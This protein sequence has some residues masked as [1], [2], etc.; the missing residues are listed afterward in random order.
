MTASH[1]ASRPATEPIAII[2]MAC[3]YPQAPDLARFWHNIIQGV[4]AVGEPVA[5][6]DA[7]RYLDSGRIKTA[8]GGYLKDLYRFDPREFGIMPNSLDGGE[9]DQFLALKVAAEALKD[10]GYLDLSHDHRD[11]GIVLGHSTYLHRGQGT[12]IQNHIVID[13][14]LDVLRSTCPHLEPEALEEV[15][16]LLAAKLPAA[17]PDIAPGLVPNV[18]TG[19]IANRLNL[20]GPN[21]LVDAACSSSLLAVNAAIDELRLGR[22]RLMIA[23]GVNASLPAEVSVIFTQLGALSGRGRVRPFETGSDGTLLGEGLGMV[24]LKRLGDALQDGDRI[25]AVLRGVGQASDGRGTGL[26][27]PSV[28]GESLAIRRAYADSGVEPASVSLIEA[29]GTGIPLGDKTEIAALKSVFGERRAGQGSM[30]LGSVKSMISHTIPAAGMAGLI[31][32]ALA[33][34]HKVLPPM[35][36]AEVNPDLGID[37]TPLYV[38]NRPAP[39]VAPQGRPR[40]AGVNSFGFGGINT[41]AILEEAP[42]LHPAPLRC[43]PWPAEL[44]LVA[45]AS[46][47]DVAAQ[48]DDLSAWLAVRPDA[49]L[50]EV[51]AALLQ[52]VDRADAPAGDCRLALVAT[53]LPGLAKQIGQARKK[54]SDSATSW[55]TRTGLC[56]SARAQEGQLAFVF[57]GEGSQYTDMLADLALCFDEV[58]DW[59]DFWCGLY[60]DAPGERR[61]D[62]VYPP[63]TGLSAERRAALEQRLHD[64][65]V[66]SEAVFI[67]GQALNRLLTSFGVQPDVML[68]HSSG[69]SSALAAS[70]A[71]PAA[72]PQELAAFIRELNAVYRAELARGT[73]PT[74]ALL[75]VGALAR[76]DIDTHRAAVDASLVV[77]MDNCANQVIVYGAVAPVE[78]LQARLTAAGAV[79]M[80]LPFDRG[81]HTPAFEPITQAFLKYY[82]SIKL[83]APQVPLY[84]CAT[85]ERFPSGTAQLRQTAAAQWSATVRFRETVRKMHADGVRT[86]VEVGPSSN[87]SNFI[88]D[89]LA[90]QPHLSLATN[91]RRKGGVDQFLSVLAQLW[92][93]RQPVRLARLTEGRA[94]RA[95]DLADR[96][97]PA[98]RG[99]AL[100]NTMPQVRLNDGDR[101]RLCALAARAPATLAAP[102]PATP[103]ALTSTAQPGADAATPSSLAAVAPAPATALEVLPNP[104]TG[105]GSVSPDPSAVSFTPVS[106]DSDN[107][108]AAESGAALAGVMADYFDLMRGF[109]DQQRAVMDRASAGAFDSE[110]LAPA[111][112]PVTAATPF[113]DEIVAHD[114]DRLKARCH[115]SLSRDQFLRD[116]VLSG[117]VSADDPQ[118]S[119][120]SCVPLM[121]SL[122]IMAQAC[123]ALAGR[124][125]VGVVRQVR[126]YD[127][128]ALDAGEVELTVEARG[129]PGDPAAFVAELSGPAGRLVS[130]EYVFGP[131][132]AGWQLPP[133]PALVQWR[134]AR[135]NDDGLY[136]SGMFHGPVFQSI[137]HIHGW[138]DAG[139]DAELSPVS[140]HG[141]F[142]PAAPATL[143]L[144]PVLLDAMGQLA[145]YWIA[146]FAGTDF[147]CFPSTIERIELYQTCPADRDGLQLRARQQSLDASSNDI[148]APRRWA[149]ECADAQGQPL[150]RVRGLVNVFYPVP[151]RF[152]Q[153]RRAPVSGWLGEPAA[154]PAA[155]GVLLW[156]LAHLPE[157]FCSQSAGIFLRL[158]AHIVLSAPERAEWAALQGTVRHRRQWLLG[159]A[160]L[161]E[162][163]RQWVHARTG[164]WLH[165]ADVIV[166]HDEL[167][168]PW[169]D[170][171]WRDVWLA[172]PEVS[173][174]HDEHGCLA[175]VG[176]PGR[177][178]GV[179]RER[180]DRVRDPALLAGALGAAERQSLPAAPSAERLLAHWCAKEAAAKCLGLGL[181]G[182]PEAFE[183]RWAD[184][185]LQTAWVTFGGQQVPVAVRSDGLSVT[186][187]AG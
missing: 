78:A 81:Y 128:I 32:S 29:H 70:G 105:P 73:I 15:R 99:V 77:A 67:G 159:R 125:D 101:Q 117:P 172:A 56:Y 126:A 151:N 74:G 170:G 94:L 17:S 121:V 79:C 60:D 109:L 90:G 57:P 162:A 12:L 176:E 157:D 31:K 164:R 82:R 153:V 7:Q 5:T 114:A 22:S 182:R 65:D 135:W 25:Y 37:D 161:K 177:A 6:W 166:W 35:L 124:V 180:L 165:S 51:A 113:L 171:A 95:L 30:A 186:A 50:A 43:Q 127:W 13:Q 18:M 38:N 1:P 163:V 129:L 80:R 4:D 184:E 28:E 154:G 21:Y 62:I 169:V 147:N 142:D 123:A 8:Q 3:M 76:E 89:I 40:R 92:V 174:S 140:L 137:R 145:A 26:L 10:A 112:D 68:G 144:N 39:W 130:A 187:L 52:R 53:D 96:R 63:P 119:G 148:A 41:H 47:A 75:A 49:T 116:H 97:A 64:M 85:A 107:G 143:V 19:R 93:H 100:D 2:G 155:P 152:Y 98:L 46:A 102:A 156:Q 11:T 103:S 134:P 139:I 54:L 87:L 48:L 23:G 9:P 185:Q 141:F 122:E 168:A 149:F 16:R 160:C 27:A 173:L 150:V 88:Q 108:G 91:Q 106:E 24:V 44:C 179:D 131:E 55:S 136:T 167:G 33:L 111:A 115:L 158:L 183:V 71:I 66:G 36:C 20:K 14:T 181:Q 69:E 120:L 175:A 138:D 34:H 178:L 83:S 118:L 58:R 132:S 104:A 110:T 72:T 42:A 45:G 86:F 84:S 59:L 146:E 133:A 61:T